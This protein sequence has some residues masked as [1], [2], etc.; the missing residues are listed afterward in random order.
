MQQKIHKSYWLPPLHLLK[1]SYP[2][3][4]YR[5]SSLMYCP[6]SLS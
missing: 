5:F 3:C 2:T 1:L 6:M 4:R